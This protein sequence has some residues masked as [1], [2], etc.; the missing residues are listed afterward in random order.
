MDVQQVAE[1]L[2]ERGQTVSVAEACTNGLL[3]YT[4]SEPFPVRHAS[5]PAVSSPIPVD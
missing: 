3:G 5:S 1:T 4:P 2:L